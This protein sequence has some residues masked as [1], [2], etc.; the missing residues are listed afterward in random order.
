M[1]TNKIL[2]QAA[3]SQTLSRITQ[4][5][6]NDHLYPLVRAICNSYEAP[7]RIA[8]LEAVIKF[9]VSNAIADISEGQAEREI[10]DMAR[11]NSSHTLSSLFWFFSE[12]SITLS[13]AEREAFEGFSIDAPG[14]TAKVPQTLAGKLERVQEQINAAALGCRFTGQ[15][16]DNYDTA[17]FL[18]ETSHE[19][20]GDPCDNPY[21]ID[22]KF[23]PYNCLGD[24][25]RLFIP[26]VNTRLAVVGCQTIAWRLT[27]PKRFNQGLKLAG[28]FSYVGGL[29]GGK[30]PALVLVAEGFKTACVLFEATGIPVVISHGCGNIAATLVTIAERGGCFS[31]VKSVLI[32]GDIGT[33]F[34]VLEARQLAWLSSELPTGE[35]YP[36]SDEPNF[37]FADQAE[38]DG[39]E[40]L[41]AAFA[42]VLEVAA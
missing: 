12:Y 42:E 3:L 22:S 13:D 17:R 11:R 18:A 9:R 25:H 20:A 5:V 33:D 28:H 30:F 7:H 14:Q 6:D 24:S 34:K 38:R 32:C 2:P 31:Q 23:T 4:H 19:R 36:D 26:I 8:T 10:L 15:V 35:V 16:F 41:M 27:P 1:E 39:I 37:D 40:S 29:V 21:V